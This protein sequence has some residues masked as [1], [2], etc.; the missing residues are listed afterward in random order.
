[1]I[2]LLMIAQSWKGLEC[3]WKDVQTLTG[4]LFSLLKKGKFGICC[5][6]EKFWQHDAKQKIP[7]S[8]K[9]NIWRWGIWLLEVHGQNP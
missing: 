5:S 6:M 9:T 7:Q 3:P 2:V 8:Q 1:M 4:T